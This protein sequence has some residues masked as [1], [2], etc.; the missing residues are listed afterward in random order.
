MK[1][2]VFFILIISIVC[3]GK[4]VD[5]SLLEKNAVFGD[6]VYR[7][8][9]DLYDDG[10][11]YTGAVISVDRGSNIIECNYKDGKLHGLYRRTS[12]S[13][14]ILDE[15]IYENG[16]LIQGFYIIYRK[17]SRVVTPITMSADG[18]E[19]F[20]LLDQ[21]IVIPG[22]DS[23]FTHIYNKKENLY[24]QKHYYSNGNLEKETKFHIDENIYSL[25]DI[26]EPYEHTGTR[27]VYYENGNI[28]IDETFETFDKK[29]YPN[30]IRK[31]YHENGNLKKERIYD[32]ELKHIFEKSYAEDGTMIEEKTYKYLQMPT[33]LGYEEEKFILDEIYKKYSIGKNAPIIDTTYENGKETTGV[34]YYSNGD[35]WK[36]SKRDKDENTE[37]REYYVDG[38]LKESRIFKKADFSEERKF[39]FRN[40]NIDQEI[41]YV[42]GKISRRIFGYYSGTVFEDVTYS[43]TDDSCVIKVFYENGA[44]F[45]EVKPK[46][47]R[48]ISYHSYFETFD[49]GEPIDDVIKYYHDNGNLY[50]LK[51]RNTDSHWKKY[52]KDGITEV[53]AKK[54]EYINDDPN[55][56]REYYMNYQLEYERYND[57]KPVIEKHYR[58]NGVP[59]TAFGKDYI[60]IKNGASLE[61]IHV[62]YYKSYYDNGQLYNE[63][64]YNKAGQENGI[65]R[66]YYENG[67]LE[68]NSLY[69]NGN[70][71]HIMEEFYE[72]GQLKREHNS[73]TDTTTIYNEDGSIAEKI[74]NVTKY[75]YSYVPSSEGYEISFD[76]IKI[77]IIGILIVLGIA[78]VILLLKYLFKN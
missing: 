23:W 74:E 24:I 16:V 2:I 55:H 19:V 6:Q 21:S 62:G 8:K 15:Y 54:D 75:Q 63:K 4:V 39:Y 44:L 34:H 3:F 42:N 18:K 49:D 60:E 32:P 41:Y 43:L 5:F 50:V 69:E 11:P 67:V 51:N 36:E 52:A 57:S 25:N 35:I 22:D 27:K 12:S 76:A 58:E 10:L 61:P 70:L 45:K 17:N 46:S 33:E 66:K 53:D 73:Y 9:I 48:P 37:Y 28:K 7:E 59:S 40:G 77:V 47:R 78:I 14:D 71:I 65:Q 38:T 64:T 26:I 30:M 68:K 20:G 31:E 56:I 72:N 1:R 13:G 29:Q